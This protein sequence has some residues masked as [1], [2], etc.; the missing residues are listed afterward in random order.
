MVLSQTKTVQN[1]I[2]H[3]ANYQHHHTCTLHKNF[4]EYVVFTKKK[5]C[6]TAHRK[7]GKSEENFF[8][9]ICDSCQYY[10]QK[11][12]KII[13]AKFEIKIKMGYLGLFQPSSINIP[14]YQFVSDIFGELICYFRLF[15]AIS[16]PFYWP[17]ECC[18]FIYFLKPYDLIH[19][20][21]KF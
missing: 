12:R 13:G 14:G 11:P 6:Q 10:P 4:P 17:G 18:F 21:T 19:Y 20:C 9:W 5:Q 15:K 1:S 2:H 3:R 7:S 8:S 16:E